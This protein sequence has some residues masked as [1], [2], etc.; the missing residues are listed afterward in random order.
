MACPLG[1]AAALAVL[2]DSPTSIAPAASACCSAPSP[3]NELTSDCSPCCLSMP[4]EATILA[5]SNSNVLATDRPTRTLRTPLA[6]AAAA[7]LGFA[8]A[9][10]PAAGL[11]DAAPAPL[12]ALLAPALTAGLPAAETL[13]AG[14]AEDAGAAG[15]APPPHAA[16]ATAITGTK[17]SFNFIAR[18]VPDARLRQPQLLEPA[19]QVLNL[20]HEDLVVHGVL[21]VLDVG[22]EVLELHSRFAA[23]DHRQDVVVASVGHEEGLAGDTGLVEARWLRREVAAEHRRAR[24]QAWVGEGQAAGHQ[25]SLAEAQQEQPRGINWVARRQVLQESAQL[26][27]RAT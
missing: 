11:A 9:D 24:H 12:A 22:L 5:G 23:Q 8:L 3:P 14:A 18:M 10:P 20:L 6:G 26:L 27:E 7:A 19:V 21:V 17:E 4:C 1:I 13:P 15:A 2:D 16:S 25:R